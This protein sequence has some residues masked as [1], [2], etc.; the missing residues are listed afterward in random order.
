M[1]G[2][3]RKDHPDVIGADPALYQPHWVFPEVDPLFDLKWLNGNHNDFH[4][5]YGSFPNNADSKYNV[6]AH[7]GNGNFSYAES[8]VGYH[9]DALA[10]DPGDDLE[11]NWM[12][13]M[14]TDQDAHNHLDLARQSIAKAK[15]AEK[16]AQEYINNADPAAQAYAAEFLAE[17]AGHYADS[18]AEKA[19]AKLI[20][21]GYLDQFETFDMKNPDDYSKIGQY[22]VDS[23]ANPY[24]IKKR[25]DWNTDEVN[26]AKDYPE[27]ANEWQFIDLRMKSKFAEGIY[28]KG[29]VL[30]HIA[31]YYPT[32]AS[33]IAELLYKVHNITLQTPCIRVSE[34]PSTSVEG[35]WEVVI[36]IITPTPMPST[37]NVNKKAIVDDLNSGR[38]VF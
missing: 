37:F 5:L 1:L 18:A 4:L 10:K 31:W 6:P 33:V 16:E 9:V 36:N 26:M 20:F 29:L 28:K 7:A 2:D 15:A 24:A 8:V 21:Q 23:W 35:E 25:V 30:D 14:V 19:A 12:N 32:L 34:T 3:W 27:P 38:F 11:G 13:T 17:A 22:W